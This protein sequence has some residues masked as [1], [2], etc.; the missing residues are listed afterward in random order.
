MLKPTPLPE[1]S[2]LRILL[3]EDDL[4]IA[5]DMEEFLHGMGCNVIGPIARLDEAI[6]RAD[7]EELHGAIVD[8]NLRGESSFPL[9]EKLRLASIPVICCSGY[10]DLPEVKSQLKDVPALSKP[11]TPDHLVATMR[12]HFVRHDRQ[13]LSAENRSSQTNPVSG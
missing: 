8:L 7:T 13:L 3:V 4:L 5:M 9:I 10:V 12:S 1:F 11:W 6:A 2:G